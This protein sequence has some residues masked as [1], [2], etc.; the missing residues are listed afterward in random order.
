MSALHNSAG[1]STV[2]TV[3]QLE[4][5]QAI[6]FEPIHM[7]SHGDMYPNKM[8]GERKCHMRASWTQYQ[9]AAW[10]I[11]KKKIQS[12]DHQVIKNTPDTYFGG[13]RRYF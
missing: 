11:L 1:Q 5:L 8:R 4:E 7:T 2:D 13:R 12:G 6:K 9:E 3:H 10:E